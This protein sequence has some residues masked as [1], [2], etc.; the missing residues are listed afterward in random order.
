MKH[1]QECISTLARDVPFR[2]NMST[3]QLY[4]LEL[5][6]LNQ[7]IPPSVPENE[8]QPSKIG[9]PLSSSLQ[10]MCKLRDGYSEWVKELTGSDRVREGERW[11]LKTGK[12]V[13][14]LQCHNL[15][16]MLSKVGRSFGSVAQ[17]W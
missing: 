6:A 7:Y 1:F 5:L 14:T 3:N 17:H 15:R 16:Q 13:S 8:P 10:S 2:K 4:T 9:S 11:S 12:M